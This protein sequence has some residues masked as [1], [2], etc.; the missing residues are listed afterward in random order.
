MPNTSRFDWAPDSIS[1]KRLEEK[2]GD[3]KKLGNQDE[4]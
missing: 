3:L 2:L 4:Y 1:L